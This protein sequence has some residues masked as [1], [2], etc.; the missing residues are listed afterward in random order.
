MS[1]I[2]E[3]L[4]ARLRSLRTE[5][6]ASLDELARRSGV[7][8]SAI[9]LVERA[10]VS[11]TAALLEKLAAALDVPLASL[12]DPPI[13]AGGPLSRRADQAAWRDP[14]T[15]Y[16]RRNVSA[17]G[18]PSPVRIVEVELPPGA[19]VAYEEAHRASPVH[20]Q[21]WVLSGRL[22]VAV[23]DTSHR[24]GRGDCLAMR[25]EGPTAFANPTTRPTR[26]A[27]VVATGPAVAA[28]AP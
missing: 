16:T 17:P 4:A 23:G 20:Q 10:E 27:V 6:G 18:W 19:T 12:F 25:L 5:R 3:T 14:Q 15:G 26:Y 28:G 7:S 22:D 11:P 9:S 8:R 24:L 2:A 21:V 1:N 13:P